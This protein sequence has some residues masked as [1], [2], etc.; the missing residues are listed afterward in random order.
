MQATHA[1]AAQLL[2]QQAD[3]IEHL[4]PLDQWLDRWFAKRLWWIFAATILMFAAVGWFTFRYAS[5][6]ILEREIAGLHA[7]SE[8][9]AKKLERWM[10]ERSV[11]TEMLIQNPLLLRLAREAQRN[12][13]GEAAVQLRGWLD[14]LQ[15]GYGYHSIEILGTGGK[16]LVL[17]GSLGVSGAKVLERLESKV[18]DGKAHF[19]DSFDT[20]GMSNYYFGY[21]AMLSVSDAQSEGLAIAL[22]STSN[23][24]S[25]FFSEL[26]AWPGEA[27]TGEIILVKPGKNGMTYLS[28]DLGIGG[29]HAHLQIPYSSDRSLVFPAA[30]SA[31]G[32][33]YQGTDHRGQDTVGVIH[34][35]VALPWGVGAQ[36][37]RREVLRKISAIGLLAGSVSLVG[38]LMSGLL[39]YLIFRQ[40]KNRA[41][42]LQHKNAA[43]VELKK[44]ADN[45]SRATNEFL[46]NTSHEIRTP[47]NA[48]VGLAYLMSQR[49]E[50]D[51]W[52]HE[53]L[54]Q[55]TDASRHLLSI[56]NNILD[57]ARI[58][59][60]KFQL[61]EVDFLLE[62]VL[63]R[64]V[65]NLVAGRAKD[66]GLEVIFDLDPAL[67]CPLRGD[68]VRLAQAILNYVGN[69]VKFTEHGRII[70]RAYPL[71]DH[72]SGLL[73]RFEVNDTGIG[74]N[75]EQQQRVF[76]AFEQADGSTTRKHGGSG[77]GLAINRHIARLMGG[78]VG[79]DSVPGVGSSFWITLRL[80]K[81]MDCMPR[82][83]ANLR[84]CRALV[85]DDLPEARMVLAKMLDTMG[86]RTAEADSGEH[87]LEML[88]KA[89]TENDPFGVMLLDWRMPGL[90]GLQTAHRLKAMP[91]AQHPLT[92]I[93]TAYDEPD[94]KQQA[95]LEG[96]R[97]VLAKPVT[98][99]T[100]HDTLARLSESEPSAAPAGHVSL[101]RQSLQTTYRGASILL[102]E[103]NPVNRDILLELLSDFGFDIETAANGR[104]ALEMAIGRTFDLV[105]MDMQMP[106]MDGL[107]ATRRM[108]ALPAWKN[109]PILA[110]T[111]NAFTEDREA[112]LAAGM[113]DHLA[114]PVEPE[115]LYSA[116]L[117]W[118]SAGEAIG[119]SAAAGGGEPSAAGGASQLNL[120]T[121]A[122]MT[123][124]KPQVM[125]RVLQQVVSHHEH[126]PERLSAMLAAQDW[127]GAFRIAHAIKGMA[128]QI[129][130]VN[131][132]QA[133][134]GAEQF[135]RQDKAAPQAVGDS[136]S[137]LLQAALAETRA[138][139]AL[140][141]NAPAVAAPGGAAIAFALAGLLR[142]HLD[143]ADGAAIQTA[144]DFKAALGDQ[145][146][147]EIRAALEALFACIARFDFDA[148]KENLLP[149]MAALEGMP[150]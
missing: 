33:S 63:T 45:A 83:T 39:L 89:G 56:I 26:L 28:Q 90:D 87:A 72:A 4:S 11:D 130:A 1:T 147:A 21:V 7:I 137:A 60:G 62:E 88:H 99:S 31:G 38:A 35:T 53:K 52:N 139:L 27:R 92:L 8:V 64:S 117:K 81:G 132:Q 103:D 57:I 75:R 129:G 78:E 113:N 67:T 140:P 51:A 119:Q 126:D 121:L 142:I 105:L 133:A 144:E 24:G 58:E 73:V 98:S 41:I 2:A 9:K 112:C 47:L 25:E 74:L 107:E 10:H 16:R 123:N 42:L 17:S 5:A 97:A 106:E 94:L 76:E 54:G 124:H 68:P 91:L 69:A 125:Q 65:F 145:A 111:A 93:V 71:E 118:L 127:A 135:W 37:D 48:I 15:K 20:E 115:V 104:L 66:K 13:A 32:T 40:Q 146:P 136:L 95:K 19:F 131:L 55:I 134:R 59:S 150:K 143:N 29:S 49:P 84:G 116:L 82:R 110:M 34:S 85:V 108:R 77:L 23:L 70:V 30:L 138:F 128:G 36:V 101:A 79:V 14:L 50:Q 86:M 114:K 44:Q 6:N 109:I 120:E 22:I 96:I 149:V 43:L 18:A 100:L 148:A 12:P 80:T 3:A 61:E 102:V 141:A 46:A 122:Q